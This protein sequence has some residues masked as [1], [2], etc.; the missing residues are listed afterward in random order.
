MYR[1]IEVEQGDIF[2]GTENVI[3]ASILTNYEPILT[4]VFACFHGQKECF[5]F[6]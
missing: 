3:R 2:H 4:V 1:Y 6:V 5:I